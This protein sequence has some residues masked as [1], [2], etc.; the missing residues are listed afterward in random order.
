MSLIFLSRT[1]GLRSIF[2]KNSA[3]QLTRCRRDTLHRL[4]PG[5]NPTSLLLPASAS[6]LSPSGQAMAP[7]TAPAPVP[8]PET[9]PMSDMD[10]LSSLNDGQMG[11]GGGDDGWDQLD[12]VNAELAALDPR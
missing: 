10:M 8:E 7:T 6:K 1:S 5:Y 12:D 11:P 4:A 9:K 3:L 2:A